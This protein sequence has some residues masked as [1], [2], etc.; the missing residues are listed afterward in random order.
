MNWKKPEIKFSTKHLKKKFLAL[1]SDKAK[2]NL[3]W[4]PAWNTKKSIENTIKWYKEFYNNP[5]NS[6]DMSLNQLNQ[7]R[8]DNFK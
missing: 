5:N 8:I 6:I 3:D 2:E 4:K 7:W 1:N